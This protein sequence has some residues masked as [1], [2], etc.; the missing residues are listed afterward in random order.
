MSI[1]RQEM[2]RLAIEAAYRSR[3]T[4]YRLGQLHIRK[5]DFDRHGERQPPSVRS[6]WCQ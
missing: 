6:R 3:F 4:Q 5:L 1:S 2:Q